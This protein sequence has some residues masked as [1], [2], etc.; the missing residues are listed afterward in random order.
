MLK[1]LGTELK[2]RQNSYQS[3]I[4]LVQFALNH[5]KQELTGY[6]PIEIMTG[7]KASSNLDAVFLP[8]FNSTLS[9]SKPVTVEKIVNHTKSLQESLDRIHREVATR[10][11]H[12]RASH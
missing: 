5:S 8:L 6:A 3:L 2:V 7:L 1:R 4:P 10:L 12:N 9:S 11:E